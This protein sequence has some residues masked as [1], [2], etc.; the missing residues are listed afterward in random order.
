MD[1]QNLPNPKTKEKTDQKQKTEKQSP[2]DLWDND[3]RSGINV[4]EVPE[5]KE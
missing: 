4:I 5:E 3:Q 2:R 1:K